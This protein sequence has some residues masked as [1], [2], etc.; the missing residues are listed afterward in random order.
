MSVELEMEIPLEKLQEHGSGNW[1]IETWMMTPYSEENPPPETL[2]FVFWMEEDKLY[3]KVYDGRE[4]RTGN[5]LCE[6]EGKEAFLTLIDAIKPFLK[7]K[8]RI[9]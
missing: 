9:L 3:Y 8:L 5:P 7:D 2:L 6:G 4:G 1:D